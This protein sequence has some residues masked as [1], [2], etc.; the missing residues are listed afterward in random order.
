MNKDT[1]AAVFFGVVG[2][3]LFCMFIW[4]I[5]LSTIEDR[6]NLEHRCHASLVMA[7]TASD[8]LKF[9]SIDHAC[10]TTLPDSL[11]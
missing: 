3:T 1:K 6:Q 10:L 8:T 11:K 5:H 7:K 4:A 9:I 2:L